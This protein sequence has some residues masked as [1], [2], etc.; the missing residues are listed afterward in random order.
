MNCEQCLEAG[1]CLYG[2]VHVLK[3]LANSVFRAWR[4]VLDTLAQMG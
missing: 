3:A 2:P 1:S 4:G